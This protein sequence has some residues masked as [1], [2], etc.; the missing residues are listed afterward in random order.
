[1][2]IKIEKIKNK[3]V[4]RIEQLRKDHNWEYEINSEIKNITV[5]ENTEIIDNNKTYE[6]IINNC[7]P[8]DFIFVETKTGLQIKIKNVDK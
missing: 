6:T 2:K 7:I 4:D 3:I 5:N 1:M 8:D